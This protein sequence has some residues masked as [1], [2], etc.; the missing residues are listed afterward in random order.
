MSRLLVSEE[1]DTDDCRSRLVATTRADDDRHLLASRVGGKGGREK[2]L[3]AGSGDADRARISVSARTV[4][5]ID[6][7]AARLERENVVAPT[8]PELCDHRRR[9]R[10]LR[11]NL[12]SC[13]HARKEYQ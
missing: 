13:A 1:V 3:V 5:R 11:G 7:H 9:S 12:A 2:G 4:G 10:L 8:R 6:D